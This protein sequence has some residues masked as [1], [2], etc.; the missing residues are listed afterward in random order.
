MS[1]LAR[2][3]CVLALV[4]GSL[5]FLNALKGAPESDRQERDLRVGDEPTRGADTVYAEA[6]PG[7]LDSP[8]NCKR[9]H[10]EIYKEWEES[11]HGQA[12]VDP[13]FKQLSQ[14]YRDESCYGCHAPR[15][16]H[17][18]K[19]QTA[20]D[21]GTRRH[22]G[23][24]CLTCHKRGNHVVGPIEDPQSYPGVEMECGP[25][26]DAN[27]PRDDA[28]QVTVDYCGVCH[29]AHGT[30]DEFLASRYAR[31]GQTCLTCHM[32][33]VYRPIVTG[34]KPRKG[35]RHTFPGAHSPEMLRTAMT[36]DARREGDTLFV[37]AINQGAGHKVPTDARHRGIHL[38][39]AFF[40]S[41]G[42]PV[43]FQSPL[44]QKR[45]RELTVDLIRLFYRHEQREPTQIAPDGTIGQ[46]NYRE[47]AVSIPKTAVGGKAVVKLYYLLVHSWPVEQKGVLVTQR[48]ISLK[49]EG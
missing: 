47:T 37:R 19:L 16:I 44:D 2:I 10:A 22:T 17:E 29:N 6:K 33:E 31:E 12:W 30:G 7:V 9:C 28:Q 34:G 45:G 18:T 5:L 24:D 8:K 3:V 13:L 27:H 36:V 26:F 25:A 23:V 32:E 20:E 21:R 49:E 1:P 35:R 40:D 48:E 42:A 15:P 39:V 4:G 38:R 14:D 41:Y 11:Y 46:P 43:A